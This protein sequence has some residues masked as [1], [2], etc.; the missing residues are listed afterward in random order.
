MAAPSSEFATKNITCAIAHMRPDASPGRMSW[1]F[2]K[3]LMIIGGEIEV[4]D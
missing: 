3:G 1:L 2:T 4:R